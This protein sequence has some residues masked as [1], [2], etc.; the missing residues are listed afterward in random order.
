[1][2]RRLFFPVFQELENIHGGFIIYGRRQYSE[3][4]RNAPVNPA[5]IFRSG[6]GRYSPSFTGLTPLAFM[7]AL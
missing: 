3:P 5:P 6:A 1:M 2:R 4:G 7:Q